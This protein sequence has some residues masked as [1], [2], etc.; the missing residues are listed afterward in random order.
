VSRLAILHPGQMG[1]SIGACAREAGAEVVWASEDRSDATRQ[2]ADADGLRDAG[3]LAAAVAGSDAVVSV[4]PPEFASALAERVFGL[5]FRGL[6]VDANATRPAAAHALAAAASDAGACFVDGGLIGPPARR[7]GS[8][9]LC[10][11]GDRAAD[12]ASL[13]TGSPVATIV[14]DGGPGAASALK[15]AFAAYTKG[16]SAL[17]LAVRALA[18][19]E[20]V[21]PELLAQWERTH[22]DLAALSE[23]VARATAP[24]AWR[25]A[26]EMEEIAATFDGVGL[27]DG[28]HRAAAEVYARFADLKDADP[29]GL[30]DVLDRLLAA[31][32][33]K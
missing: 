5:G 30:T 25:F 22:P 18:R 29:A 20:G 6:F 9:V 8:T 31:D 13:F 24:K 17:L 12:A 27:P 28:F 33:S 15:M 21:E 32:G 14:L 19:G 23:G 7:A 11:S 10:L 1:S 3:S 26:P 2:R 16:H 4:C